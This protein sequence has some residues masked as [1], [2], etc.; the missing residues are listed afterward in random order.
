MGNAQTSGD[1]GALGAL[2][3]KQG[4]KLEPQ[5]KKLFESEVAELK[6]VLGAG[7]FLGGSCGSCVGG[8]DALQDYGN[9]LFSRAKEK[10]IREIAEEVFS[11]LKISG[12]KNAKTAP[13]SDVVAHLK[14]LSPN[15]TKG[16]RFNESFNS[17]SGKQKAVCHAL[18]AA[19]NNNYGG[20]IINMDASDSEMCNQV[21]EVM[22]SLLT[23]LHTEFLNVAGDVTRIMKNMQT[24]EAALTAAY[25]KQV[26]LVNASGDARLKDQSANSA[27][28]YTE[29]KAEYDRQAAVLANLMNVAV[30]PAAKSIISSLEDNRDFA[31][32]VRDLKAETGTT[33][34]GDK[35]GHLLS[36]I[37]TVA[38]SAEL[39]DKALR[40]IGMSV[41]EFKSAKSAGDLRVKVLNTIMKDSPNSK[42]LDEMMAASQIIFNNNYNHDAISKLLNGS[43]KSSG[44]KGRGESFG[45]DAEGFEGGEDGVES[46]DEVAGGADE[47]A[48]LPTYWQKKSLSKKIE[49]KKK[50]RD[51]VLADFRKLL[52][53]H[54]Q[55]VVEAANALSGKVG[56]VIPVSDALDYFIQAF[57]NLPN[58]NKENFHVALSGYAKDSASKQRRESFMNDYLLLDQAIEPLTK[59]PEGNLFK[60]LQVAVKAMVKS[61]DDFS[62]KMVKAL[63]EI[64]IDRPDEIQAALKKSGN[65]FYGSAD[66]GDDMFG[67]GNWVA[68]DKVKEEMKYFYSIS[69]IKTNMA[70]FADDIKS[71]SDE[72]EQ[73]LGEEAGWLINNIKKEFTERLNFTD[74]TKGW[75]ELD[76]PNKPD[77]NSPTWNIHNGLREYHLACTAA[78]AVD[79]ANKDN[80]IKAYKNLVTIWTAQMNAKETM[81]KVAQAV[82]LYLKSFTDGISRNPDAISSVVK[83]LDQ[84]DIVAKWFNEKSGDNLS[85][86]FETFPE[87]VEVRVAGP[88]AAPIA[89]AAL[90]SIPTYSYG[91]ASAIVDE[92]GSINLPD[93][94]HYYEYVEE[95]NAGD[96]LPGN[97][98]LGRPLGQTTPDQLKGIMN[99][100]EKS[101]KGMRALENILSAFSSVGSKFGDLDPQSRT[102]MTPGQMFN[103]LMEYIKMSAFTTQFAA[104]TKADIGPAGVANGI[105]L[106]APVTAALYRSKTETKQIAAAGGYPDQTIPTIEQNNHRP[107]GGD[108]DVG[109]HWS[110]NLAANKARKL[111]EGGPAVVHAEDD[112]NKHGI[113]TGVHNVRELAANTGEADRYRTQAMA[114][115]A[116]PYDSDDSVVNFWDYHDFA[117]RTVRL[118]AAG[119]VDMFYDTDLLFQM[120]I[121]SI[122]AKIF[123]VVD[124]YRLF[125]RPTMNREMSYS[126]NP[127]RTILGGVNK[128]VKII[129]EAAE[130]YLRLPLLAEWYREQ[131]GF[132]NETVAPGG[133]E[134]K[135]SIVPAIDGTWSDFINIVFDKTREVKEGNYT[136]S[137]TQALIL[138]MNDIFK[139]YK[140]RYPKATIRNII[141]S[142]VLEMNRIFGFMKQSEINAYLNQKREYL[143]DNGDGFAEDSI[144][145]DILNANDQ[146]GFRPA[147]SD[148]FVN[149]GLKTVNKNRIGMQKLQSE[150]IKLRRNVD[151]SLNQALMSNTG[152]DNKVRVSF[153]ETL[154]N[155]KKE[156][157]TAK[158]DEDQY[159]V[160]LQII[161]GANKSVNLS[162]D[163][164]VMLHE[165]VATPLALLYGIYKILTKY[166][167]LVH[168]ASI[169]N[170]AEWNAVRAANPAPAG[171]TVPAMRAALTTVNNVRSAY[172]AYLATK[173]NKAARSQTENVLNAMIDMFTGG[174]NNANV[175]DTN[176]KYYVTGGVG[177]V[178]A[179][180]PFSNLNIDAPHLLQDLLNAIADLSTNSS[181]LVSCSIGTSGT[182][183]IDFSP[184]QDLC[185]SLL[186]QV[187][188]N[189][190]KLRSSFPPSA[191]TVKR[192]ED[193]G[194]IGS[195]RWLEENLV[196]VLFNDRDQYGLSTGYS[197]HLVKT[198]EC[199]TRPLTQATGFPTIDNAFRGLIYYEYKNAL[200]SLPNQNAYCNP[201]KFPW[202]VLALKKTADSAEEKTA[203]NNASA[204]VVLPN[205]GGAANIVSAGNA[206]FP[207]PVILFESSDSINKFNIENMN[208]VA[209]GAAVAENL[210]YNSLLTRFNKLVH[211][212]LYTNIEDGTL[213][214]YTPLFEAFMNSAAS[215]EVLQGNA[216]PNVTL[217]NDAVNSTSP[218]QNATG[219]NQPLQSPPDATVLFASTAM[220]MKSLATNVTVLGTAQKKKH[221]YDN[222][223]EI[224]EFLKER[225][226]INLPYFSKLFQEVYDRADF[227]KKVL[228]YSGAKNNLESCTR[229]VAGAAAPVNVRNPIV[230]ASALN[231]AALSTAENTDYLSGLLTRFLEL[232]S[233]IKKCCDSVYKELN[234]KP[235]PFLETSKEFIA[236]YKRKNGVMPLMPV[237]SLLAPA[238]VLTMAPVVD[239][240]SISHLMLP[241]ETNGSNVYKFNSAAKLIMSDLNAEPNI[242][243][244]PGA[245]EI[246][247]MYAD[248]VDGPM[249]SSSEYANTVKLVAKLAR[250]VNTGVVQ[251]RMFGRP[252]RLPRPA[253]G[254]HNCGSVF[255]LI[256]EDTHTTDSNGNVP[257]A[258]NLSIA[259]LALSNL[260]AVIELTE[261]SNIKYSKERIAKIVAGNIGELRNDAR[262]SLRVF[263]IL[264]MNIVP[265]NVHAFMREI[266]F[267]NILNYAYTFDRMVHDFVLPGYVRNLGSD[268]TADNIMIKPNSVVANPRELLVKLLAHPYADLGA[269]DSPQYFGALASLFNGNDDMKLG[270][271]RYLSDQLWH[272]ALLTSSI[273]LG[274]G[275]TIHDNNRPGMT[276]ANLALG[277]AGYEAQRSV[278]RV[279]RDENKSP[280]EEKLFAYLIDEFASRVHTNP[281]PPVVVVIAGINVADVQ[282]VL[283]I[284]RRSTIRY[285]AAARVDINHASAV[286]TAPSFNRATL[287]QT[288]T[289][290]GV[291][292]DPSTKKVLEQ[293]ARDANA[294]TPNEQ[295]AG[296]INV[297]LNSTG[298]GG[299]AIALN[300]PALIVAINNY[301]DAPANLNMI[302]DL[303][304]QLRTVLAPGGAVAG[305]VAGNVDLADPTAVIPGNAAG[306]GA[307]V[308]ISVVS[309]AAIL[310]LNN[311]Q[312]FNG[313][314]KLPD[315]IYKQLA[316]AIA[317]AGAANVNAARTIAAIN[318]LGADAIAAGAVE[319]SRDFT[320][321]EYLFSAGA[322][323]GMA[324]GANNKAV[325]LGAVYSMFVRMMMNDIIGKIE[326]LQRIVGNGNYHSNRVA[327]IMALEFTGE[328]V[329]TPGMKYRKNDQ[330]SV[331]N[332][333]GKNMNAANVIYCA[334]LGRM[335][336]DTKLVRN[337]SWLV[338]LQRMMRV[339]L[340][341]HLSWIN[342]PVVRGLKIADPSVTEYESNDKY[343]DNDY[344]GNKYALV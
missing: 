270:R 315:S 236:D 333:G 297:I 121:K 210:Q 72:Y 177:G 167:L 288:A 67:S 322:A 200:Y 119:W 304:R 66:S 273:Q 63:T 310:I 69:N 221:A 302:P 228:T 169:I 232:S 341:G 19:I 234:D 303:V 186:S 124:A 230:N 328:P 189:I 203:L 250:F 282:A 56:R 36:G 318:A 88:P 331:V 179:D 185:T 344:T 311:I 117:N 319:S 281:G 74:P 337:L 268:I 314:P 170:L 309:H 255:N 237:S 133:T 15:P 295:M 323:G 103:G 194:T 137:Q 54:Y 91:A 338:Q 201:T 156:L 182:I 123:T 263:N 312:T 25:N 51:F 80:G 324:A 147:P 235:V 151:A 342:T 224:P 131:Y 155:Y 174:A 9:S 267:V 27:K 4:V 85:Y 87:K 81:V 243:H 251:A 62:E 90:H 262:E 204:G 104:E 332:V 18:A 330:W 142:F 46:E 152:T 316:C 49:N 274:L 223:A 113:L 158:S 239:T 220:V 215:K 184:L 160:V 11:A 16:K 154:K 64:H 208:P 61:I 261:N 197:S 136:E 58:L 183:N 233:S 38:H 287:Q 213:K 101:I 231:I 258:D 300:P 115:S 271:P 102:F 118:D 60:N 98:F 140:S 227:L 246:Y 202:N 22:Y 114:M 55:R 205:G 33:A 99:L 84:V 172:K 336:F 41:S 127:L 191:D 285:P 196:E 126:L 31:G 77:V 148:K 187:K 335:R 244:F 166:N 298:V 290:L 150:V 116:I 50:N 39:I 144:D 5:Y 269:N 138:A 12:A 188:S 94:K 161:Q 334:E 108:A 216:F 3:E 173:Y 277:P 301:L 130:L 20:R 53:A 181:K 343:D 1:A 65:L 44:K 229:N 180:A 168:G 106:G 252:N 45:G 254:Q 21:A 76:G 242:D 256:W 211:M 326:S 305:V 175:D 14:K 198:I 2:Y 329:Q 207:A 48:T 120:S 34:F 42:E 260:G 93:K 8:Y 105:G 317:C 95:Q 97:P 192:Y 248:A 284:T 171:P 190:Q 307:A 280:I 107:E 57:S 125:N 35:L 96:R 153:I 29:I 266:P 59:G 320:W 275:N 272:K 219:I 265:I 109:L 283:Q 112:R 225:M 17:S 68:F 199:L 82:D 214:I 240:N 222:V 294:N 162:A 249:I 195:A 299:G 52:R 276:N 32:L 70:R 327:N 110:S 13:I 209:G 23:G 212:Y 89:G 132:K 40:K 286:V 293:L 245:K 176:C 253:A 143:T 157:E 141:N 78:A 30:G 226:R 135:L 28:L 264:D 145:F 111:K 241:V 217:A 26:E 193:V 75:A 339:V 129:P 165:A 139:A 6:G 37:S 257:A 92:K 146:F 122:V 278:Q 83:M 340:I 149:V 259:P 296:I 325:I 289:A 321:K 128:I 218:L 292:R 163:K 247:N 159:Q 73:L 313:T 306:G 279:T 43:S 164:L 206:I 7:E 71:Y 238:K 100:T 291:G 24:V 308:D 86:L 79:P 134:W 10:L 47:D 178:I